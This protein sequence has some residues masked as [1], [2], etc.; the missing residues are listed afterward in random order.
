M[1]FFQMDQ[2]ELS[3]WI[4]TLIV[5]GAGWAFALGRKV[6]TSKVIEEASQIFVKRDIHDLEIRNMQN[7]ITSNH[8]DLVVRL[9]KAVEQINQ[10]IDLLTQ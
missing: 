7:S 10:K 6:I 5:G 1:D 8:A 2:A 3:R 4:I 9:D